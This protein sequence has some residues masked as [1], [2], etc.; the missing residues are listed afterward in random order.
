[1]TVQMITIGGT[2]YA[3]LKSEELARLASLAHVE[4]SGLIDG[5][6]L[7]PADAD[8]YRPALA[9]V[10]VRIAQDLIAS[11]R[12]LGWSQQDLADRAGVRQES[13]SRIESGRH[14]PT[15][16]TMTKIDKAIKAEELRKAKAHRRRPRS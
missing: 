11:R 12:A 9:T 15:M 2:E 3:L 8:G 5:P 10:R 16:R 14:T 13:I 1:M 4:I 6:A 7:P